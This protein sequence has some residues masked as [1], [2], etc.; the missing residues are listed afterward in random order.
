MIV[1]LKGLIIDILN[2]GEMYMATIGRWHFLKH[3]NWKHLF[4]G[5]Y[6]F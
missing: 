6:M 3:L 4:P 1:L 5:K 2:S